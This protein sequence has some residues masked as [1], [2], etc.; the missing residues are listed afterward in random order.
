MTPMPMSPSS[1]AGDPNSLIELLLKAFKEEVFT[2]GFTISDQSQE[3]VRKMVIKGVHELVKHTTQTYQV[4]QAEQDIR[5]FAQQMISAAR[6]DGRREL[7]ETDYFS[8]FSF[9]C[10]L[11]PFC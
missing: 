1:P 9:L 7:K 8:T 2:A 11:W 6:A 10:P 3:L 4:R 5:T